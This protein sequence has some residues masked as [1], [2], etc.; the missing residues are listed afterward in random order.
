MPRHYDVS[1]WVDFK[2]ALSL[3]SSFSKAVQLADEVL[4]VKN[5]TC[6]DKAESIRIEN[7]RRD[8]VELIDL[9]IVYDSMTCVVTAL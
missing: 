4:G 8:E 9:T 5:H 1:T 6:T 2:V 7:T 3:Y